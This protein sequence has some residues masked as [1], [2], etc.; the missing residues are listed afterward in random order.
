MARRRKHIQF[1]DQP[2]L[3][4]TPTFLGTQINQS[5]AKEAADYI[6]T[7]WTNEGVEVSGIGKDF[8]SVKLPQVFNGIS[9]MF[10]DFT[11]FN[12]LVD[13]ELEEDGITL[14]I[15]TKDGE[16]PEEKERKRIFRF[17]RLYY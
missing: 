10:A 3:K 14:K 13:Q 6:Q 5:A 8:I 11:E 15:Y 1:K 12:F 7:H 9:A 4:L 16:V 2:I 17:A